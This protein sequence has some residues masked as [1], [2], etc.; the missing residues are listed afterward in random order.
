MAERPIRIALVNQEIVRSSHIAGS[1]IMVH[2]ERLTGAGWTQQEHIVV[3]N[4]PQL[5]GQF[6]NI[7]TLRHQPDAVAH[8]EHTVRD[9]GVESFVNSQ[10]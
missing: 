7:E 8:F 4:Q 9:A 10:T 6:L 3:L 5:Q 1:K 2:K